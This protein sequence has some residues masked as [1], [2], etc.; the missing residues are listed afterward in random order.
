MTDNS[1]FIPKPSIACRDNRHVMIIF[2]K[3]NATLIVIQAAND[4]K[5]YAGIR[6][7]AELAHGV[8]SNDVSGMIVMHTIS[9]INGNA[10]VRMHALLGFRQVR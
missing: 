5:M 1:V 7:F 6:S 2:M 10:P 9:I 3:T 4:Q 8:V